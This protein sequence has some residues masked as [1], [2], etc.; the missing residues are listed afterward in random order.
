MIRIFSLLVGAFFTISRG[1]FGGIA[2][3][4]MPFEADALHDA[5]VADVETRDDAAT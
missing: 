5:S 1:K 3:V 4:R 2:H